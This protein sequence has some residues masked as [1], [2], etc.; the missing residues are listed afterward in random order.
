M[1]GI[2]GIYRYDGAPVDPQWLERMRK[3]MADYGPDGGG[4]KIDGSVGMGHLL[5]EVNPEDA[6]ERQPMR[7]QRG[8]VVASVRLD[9]REALL[10]AFHIPSSEAPEISDGHLVS[11]AFDR[12]G[13]EVCTHLEGDWALAAWDAKQRR[14]LLARDVIGMAALYYHQGKGFIVFASSLKALLALPGSV[15]EADPLALAEILLA[16]QHDAEL[17]AYKGFKR[18]PWAHHMCVDSC[19]ISRSSRY[20]SPEGRTPLQYRN[21]RDYVEAFIELYTQAVRSC[22]RTSRNIGAQLSGG[23]DSGSILALAAPLLAAEGRDL[24]AFTSVPY[25]S[26]DGAGERQMGDE[27]DMAHATALMAGPNVRHLPIDA[28]D[29]RVIAGIEHMID[30]HDGPSQAAAN[31]YWLLAIADAAAETD[32]SVLLTGQLG[33]GTVS[34]EGNGSAALA[35]LQGRLDVA[36]RVLLRA[37]PNPW[38]MIKRQVLKP[39]L[40]PS[41]LGLRHWRVPFHEHWQHYS[42]LNVRM[43]KDLNLEERMRSAGYDPRLNFSPLVDLRRLLL[44]PDFGI[45]FSVISDIT[46][47]RSAIC[48][49]PTANLSLLEFLLRVPDDQFYRK[50]QDSS[51]F[52]R[53][54]QNRLPEPVLYQHLKGLQSADI[55]HRILKEISDFQDCLSVLESMPE[56]QA[57]LDLS[58][59]RS[60]LT[61]LVAR[62]DKQS[63]ARASTI[64]LRAIAV[65]LFLCRLSIST[66]SSLTSQPC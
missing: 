24:M 57:L 61:D 33:N 30:A 38:L 48:I 39:L 58:L 20:W 15:T 19:G 32:T 16:W 40:K 9:N 42:A 25:L 62:V 46:I 3:A 50:G 4:G 27:W 18:L 1:S 2:Y 41:I 36:V 64:L 10:D 54:F 6:F 66:S 60:C 35:I 28:K 8:M 55:G 47:R 43:A 21:D 59:V 13:E 12:W 29:Y 23:R 63:T 52:K 14:L 34:W 53:A 26:P 56:A 7:C 5:L 17:T 22:L 31:H 37:E 65:G 51:L 49:D 11:L 45:G 44:M